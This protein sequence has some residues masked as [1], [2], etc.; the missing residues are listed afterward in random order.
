MKKT[1]VTIRERARASGTAL[2]LDIYHNGERKQESLG[3]LLTKD[4][5]ANRETRR[6]A[7][8]KRVRRELSLIDHGMAR[9]ERVLLSDL[10]RSLD[11]SNWRQSAA[12]IDR[13][14]NVSLNT[15]RPD[16]LERYERF[17]LAEGLKPNSAVTYVRSVRAAIR[18]AM[19]Q[20]LLT[21]DP[22]LGARTG[23]PV[24]VTKDFLTARELQML[25][26]TPVT[27][28][29]GHRHKYTAN[30]RNDVKW[31]YL[32]ACYQGLRLEDVSLLKDSD[33]IELNG[34][35]VLTLIQGKTRR[36]VVN[37]LHPVA[38]KIVQGRTGRLF[39]L[40]PLKLC[41]YYIKRTARAAGITKNVTFHTS[42]HTAAM[43][44]LIS[45]NGNIMAVRDHLG[46]TNV[47]TTLLYAKMLPTAMR[48]AVESMPGIEI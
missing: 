17:L 2:Y 40:P 10:M 46:H 28:A 6:L 22:F 8:E 34:A 7:E 15:L 4:K 32:F 24:E 1:S 3:L 33:I 5:Q 26:D 19:R 43:Q 38:Q 21:N 11:R 23:Q 13:F 37:P 48:E 47:R 12:W 29:I 14:D 20:G 18:Y 44:L 39:D 42:R 35:P 27:I 25:A 41:T 45:S 31:A 36:T 9:P 16:Y 30:Q